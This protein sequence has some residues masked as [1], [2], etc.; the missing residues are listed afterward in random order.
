MTAPTPA[1][2]HPS[3]A[4]AGRPPGTTAAPW[5]AARIVTVV[6]GALGAVLGFALLVTGGA[7]VAA[8]NDDDG[9]LTDGEVTLRS[10]GYAVTVREIG[11]NGSVPDF[12]SDSGGLGQVRL[13]AV[14]EDAGTPLFVGIAPRADVDR[15][16]TG[17]GNDEVRDFEVDPF[18]VDYRQHAGG[19]PGTSPGDQP[20]WTVSN[21]GT[22]SRELEWDIA[23]GEWAVVV[24]N[25]DASAGVDATVDV[26]ASV[27]ALTPVGIGFLVVGGAVLVTGGVVIAVAATRRRRSPYTAVPVAPAP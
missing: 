22:G 11:V 15:Y 26:G 20:F 13:R 25:A 16:L 19:P 17:V 7:L 10:A 14:S 23:P 21:A 8:G 24:M 9:Y 27:P 3:S 4:T 12:V 1:P 18:R 6:L 5:S 2:A